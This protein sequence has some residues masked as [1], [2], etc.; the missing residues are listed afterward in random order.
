MSDPKTLQQY[1]DARRK[2]IEASIRAEMCAGNKPKEDCERTAL[3]EITALE[4]WLSTRIQTFE[5]LIA[6][7][8]AEYDREADPEW[9][10]N[11]GFELQGLRAA[12]RAI[13]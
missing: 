9:K 11:I 12:R 8:K 7:K 6:S 10:R 5:K 3:A 4:Q 1:L 2:T 13:E